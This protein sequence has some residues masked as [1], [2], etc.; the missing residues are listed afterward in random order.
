MIVYWRSVIAITGV[1]KAEWTIAEL[2]VTD[3]CSVLVEE[4]DAKL[5]VIGPIYMMYIPALNNELEIQI[6]WTAPA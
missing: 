2:Y 4:G 1:F 5:K 6:G 3:P